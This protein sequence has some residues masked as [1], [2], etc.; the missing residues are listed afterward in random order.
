MPYCPL[1]AQHA[2]AL[3]IGPTACATPVRMLR[4]FPRQGGVGRCGVGL[5]RD[6]GPDRNVPLILRECVD[7]SFLRIGGRDVSDDR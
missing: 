4:T 3:A 7:D 2:G 6:F 5:C 1:P